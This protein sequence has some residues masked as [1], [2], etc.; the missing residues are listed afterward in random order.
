MHVPPL[1]GVHEAG[2]SNPAVT[3]G[4][5]FTVVLL[6]MVPVPPEAGL[7][8]VGVPPQVMSG[9]WRGEPRKATGGKA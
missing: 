4:A 8:R 7:G 9:A 2:P 3:I 5:A 1:A 6:A